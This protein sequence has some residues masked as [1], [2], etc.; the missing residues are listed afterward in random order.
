MVLLKVPM[1][2]KISK[3]EGNYRLR[4]NSKKSQITVSHKQF[5]LQLNHQNEEFRFMNVPVK[6]FLPKNH[7]LYPVKVLLALF[8]HVKIE[9]IEISN[10]F[11]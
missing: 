5:R 9:F 4:K 7:K 11:L 6:Y 1:S 10:S 8:I 3:S 2:H